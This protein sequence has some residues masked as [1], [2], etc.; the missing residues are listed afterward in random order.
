MLPSGNC[1]VSVPW[2]RFC[3]R[4][5]TLRAAAGVPRGMVKLWWVR[6]CCSWWCVLGQG[7]RVVNVVGGKGLPKKGVF[8]QNSLKACQWMRSTTPTVMAG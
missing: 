8:L 1:S 4:R 6:W 2:R 7:Q 5:S 3:S